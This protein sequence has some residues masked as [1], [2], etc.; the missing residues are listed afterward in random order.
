MRPG[1]L[2]QRI[3]GTSTAWRL[4]GLTL[5]TSIRATRGRFLGLSRYLQESEA[6]IRPFLQYFPHRPSVLEFGCGPGGVLLS[7]R[8]RVVRGI[9]I[10]IN[11][12]Y[13]RH[14]RRLARRLGAANLS[15]WSYDGTAFPEVGANFD[16]IFAFGTFERIPKGAARTYFREVGRRMA[17]SATG[18]IYLLSPAAQSS[19]FVETLGP[20]AYT[21]W[22]PEEAESA[23]R[24]VQLTVAARVESGFV[25]AQ[26]GGE[27]VAA[28]MV[29]VCRKSP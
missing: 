5:A 28:G 17:D 24:E 1:S 9:G 18:L 6:E 2:R 15:F 19:S 12:W 13:V 20:D 21:Y 23:F 16:V 8:D 25:R 3:L 22:T 14:A 4:S 11:P 7:V 27:R 26:G 29:Y 10:D